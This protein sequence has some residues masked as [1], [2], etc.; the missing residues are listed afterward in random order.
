MDSLN[1]SQTIAKQKG[2]HNVPLYCFVVL[3]S[4]QHRIEAASNAV[5]F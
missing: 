5:L 3:L 2:E 1:N 4:K